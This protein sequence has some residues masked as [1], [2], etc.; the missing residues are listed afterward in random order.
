M[1]D[2][3]HDIPNGTMMIRDLGYSVEFYFRTGSSTWNN[4]QWWSWAA[5][6]TGARQKS[7]IYR[8]GGWNFFG[9]I[10][11]GYDQTIRFTIENSGLGWPNSDFYQYIPRSTT[12]QPPTM[13]TV[14]TV[15]D[16]QLH[17]VFVG[18][19][20]GGS[21]ILEW[22]VGF[23]TSIDVGP[24]RY[25]DSD[26]DDIFGSFAPGE[27]IYAWARGRNALG[28]GGWSNRGEATLWQVP[29]PPADPVITAKSQASV[30]LYYP[31]A[32]LPGNA[33]TLERQIGYGTD[34]VTPSSFISDI[35]GGAVITGLT[36]GGTYYFWSRYRNSV[37]WGAWSSR[38]RIDL[39]AGALVLVGGVWKRAVTYMKVGGVWKVVEPWVKNQGTW[40]R[41]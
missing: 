25:D 2:Y 23:G 21:P 39:T 1:A 28:W 33:P 24:I 20:D 10:N 4:D 41:T 5:N 30:S 35:G 7:A 37:G 13:I 8:G 27:R 9:S 31:I 16:T 36:P 12:P 3:T 11:V 22:Q 32:D 15:S 6:G 26:G 40:T 19:S 29:P 34:P 18:N 17:V 14:E 38:T